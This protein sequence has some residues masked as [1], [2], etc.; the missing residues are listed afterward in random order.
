[1]SLSQ[2]YGQS[3]GEAVLSDWR[4]RLRRGHPSAQF[5]NAG[6]RQLANRHDALCRHKP[7][8]LERLDPA[9]FHGNVVEDSKRRTVIG[10]GTKN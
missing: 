5:A 4:I 7:D 1:M 9:G 3:P 2:T 10:N 8:G 6:A